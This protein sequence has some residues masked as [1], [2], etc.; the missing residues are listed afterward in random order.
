LLIVILVLIELLPVIAKSWL[1]DGTYDEKVRL[2][3]IMEKQI[4]ETNIQHEGKSKE[5]Y[6]RPAYKQD[7]E[8]IC[9]FFGEARNKSKQKLHKRLQQWKE[10]GGNFDKMWEDLKRDMLT[11]QEN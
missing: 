1:P 10:S 4:T 5:M 2:R 9:E 8:F 11:K 3:E 7:S 6:N